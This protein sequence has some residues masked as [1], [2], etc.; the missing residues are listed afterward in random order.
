MVITRTSI[1]IMKMSVPEK[2]SDGKDCPLVGA[3]LVR[4]DGSH[5]TACRGGAE[6][7]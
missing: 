1:D 2:R 5:E 6:R 4:P 3:V 7:W